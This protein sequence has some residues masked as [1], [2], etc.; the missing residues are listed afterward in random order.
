MSGYRNITKAYQSAVSLRSQRERDAEVFDV[1]A[2]RLRDGKSAGAI[3]LAKA[4]ADNRTLWQTVTTVTLDDNNP[5]PAA[6]R[7]SLLSLAASVL[8]EMREA[9]PN[10]QALIEINRNVAAGLRGIAPAAGDPAAN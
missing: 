1:I 10:I 6:I 5:Q 3:P 7:K 2:A 9:K 4:L 8:R